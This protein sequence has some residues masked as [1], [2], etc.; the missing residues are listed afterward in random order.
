MFSFPESVRDDLVDDYTPS[1][2]HL[3]AFPVTRERC[4][5]LRA[6]NTVGVG[7][8]LRLSEPEQCMGVE[9]P[10]PHHNMWYLL[11]NYET[12]MRL[13]HTDNVCS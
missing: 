1:K 3:R 6:P 11:R 12:R 10:L 5:W 8:I 2:E 7:H 9:A 13:I 4:P